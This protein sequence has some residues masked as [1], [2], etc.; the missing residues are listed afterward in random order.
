MSNVS[1]RVCPRVSFLTMSSTQSQLPTSTRDLLMIQTVDTPTPNVSS[2]FNVE[3]ITKSL[4][5]TLSAWSPP[6]CMDPGTTFIRMI[7]M[8]YQPS[9]NLVTGKSGAK[10]PWVE[11]SFIIS[12]LAD[13]RP[14]NRRAKLSGQPFIVRG[15]GKP[16]RQFM[17]SND[18]ARAL[19]ATLESNSNESSIIAPTEE[20]TIAEVAT[21][22]ANAFDYHNMVFDTSYSD[23]QYRKTVTGTHEFDFTPLD[24]GIQITVAWY[25]E[26]LN[27]N[28]PSKSFQLAN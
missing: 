12:G 19:V 25:L 21:L 22:V 10:G 20:Y 24:E 13:A 8:L 9:F 2:S 27:P 3:P 28:W 17:F 11:F 18:F 14:L 15:S 7:H 26:H 23:G 5:Q 4:E 6:T 16:L 1:W